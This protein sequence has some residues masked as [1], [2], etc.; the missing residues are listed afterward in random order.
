MCV[1]VCVRARVHAHM[2][3]DT[4]DIKHPFILSIQHPFK[5]GVFNLQFLADKL[6]KRGGEFC[7]SHGFQYVTK[8]Q[9]PGDE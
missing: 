1:C 2:R 6:E 8:S 4:K 3:A 9:P 5:V 7:L